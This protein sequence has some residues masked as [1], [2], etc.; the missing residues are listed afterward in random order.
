MRYIY[1]LYDNEN[2]DQETTEKEMQ[3]WFDYTNRLKEAGYLLGGEALQPSSTSTT[4]RGKPG[5]KHDLTD[6][7]Y[8]ETKEALGGYYLVDVPDLDTAIEWA[9]QVPHVK[10]G[11]IVEVRPIMEIDAG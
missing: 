11:G 6:G 9:A 5:A 10:R 4:V 3:E 2:V 1:L 8:A 7:P